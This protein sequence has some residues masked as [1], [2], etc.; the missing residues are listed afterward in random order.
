MS[1][2]SLSINKLVKERWRNPGRQKSWYNIASA[3]GLPHCCSC[4][5]VTHRY[6]H[7]CFGHLNQQEKM[8]LTTVMAQGGFLNSSVRNA[9]LSAW[10]PLSVRHCLNLSLTR[11][12]R[13]GG[14]RERERPG[15]AVCARERAREGRRRK[16]GLALV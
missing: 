5:C 13:G 7:E 10:T 11:R 4:V 12:G 3:S 9:E 15:E 8:F 6:I 2:V 1:R 14:P 16:R